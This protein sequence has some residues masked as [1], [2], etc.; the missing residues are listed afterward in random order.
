[1]P[2]MEARLSVVSYSYHVLCQP[3]KMSCVLDMYGYGIGMVFTYAVVVQL[4]S[5]V[6][7]ASLE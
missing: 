7:S 4:T 1:M 5:S 2:N 6:T 3:L